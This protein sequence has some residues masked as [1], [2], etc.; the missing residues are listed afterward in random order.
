MRAPFPLFALLA[1]VTASGCLPASTPLNSDRP[2]SYLAMR[3]EATVPQ[4]QDFTCG[5]ASLATVLTFYW[6]ERTTESDVLRALEGR[7]T[8][9]EIKKKGVSGLS[10]DD[11]IYAAERL[12]FAAEGGKVAEAELA[13]LEGPVI[14]R[15]KKSQTFQHFVVLRKVGDGVFYLSDPVVGQMSQS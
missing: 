9:E 2:F 10:F 3:Y 8:K 13:K 7:Y 5:A 14:V 1:A 6:G 4:L 15:L 11:L 12:G